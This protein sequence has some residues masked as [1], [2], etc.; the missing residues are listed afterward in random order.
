MLIKCC[1]HL[2]IVVTRLWEIVACCALCCACV[3][4]PCD[5][6]P[7][8]HDPA[9]LLLCLSGGG[10]LQVDRAKLHPIYR[11]FQ[12]RESTQR[13]EVDTGRGSALESRFQHPHA[14]QVVLATGFFFSFQLGGQ[15][16]NF[17][18]FC[19]I[20]PVTFFGHLCLRA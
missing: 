5:C 2:V 9:P 20:L 16:P 4:F 10:N 18:C 8:G 14:V 12:K 3:H 1:I 15:C 17:G 19:K 6:T 11:R 13:L 7:F